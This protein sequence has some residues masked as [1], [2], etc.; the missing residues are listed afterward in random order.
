MNERYDVLIR[1]ASIIDGTGAPA[2]KATSAS[3]AR[4][5]SA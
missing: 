3:K 1:N 2:T 4:A 5:L